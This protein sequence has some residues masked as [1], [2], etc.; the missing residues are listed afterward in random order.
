[1]HQIL[2]VLALMTI[3][4]RAYAGNDPQYPVIFIPG[5]AASS[6]PSGQILNF[7]FNRGYPPE[8]LNLSPSY[9]TLVRKLEKAGYE[10]GITFFAAVYDWR[11]AAAPTDGNY[12]GQLENVTAESVTSGDYSYAVNYLGYWLDQAV[13]ANPG[14]E[15]VD[16][17]THSTGGV[18][19]RAYIQS[20]AYGA[21]YIDKNHVVR[22]LPKIRYLI[23]GAAPTFGAPHSWRPWHGDFQDVLTGFIPTTEIE[24]RVAAMAFAAVIE[25]K[26]ISGPDYDITEDS[27]LAIDKKGNL[28]PDATKF[29]RLYTPMRR[30]LM[31]TYN[32]LQSPGSDEYTNV[33]D[34][35]EVRSDVLLDL[36]ALSTP[37]NNPWLALIG[38]AEGEGGAIATYATGARVKTSY[39]D[40]IIPG[41]IDK[42]PFI[43]T[44]NYVVQLSDNEGSYLPLLA[45]LEPNPTVIPVADSLF[46]RIGNTEEDDQLD[47]DGNGPFVSL[48]GD[49]AE[50]P[51][52]TLVQWA[53]GL[54]LQALRLILYGTKRPDIR[55]IMTSFF[56]TKMSLSLSWTP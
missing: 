7:V 12:D 4:L 55:F 18:L 20:P 41:L 43:S 25:G 53:M 31:A 33:N 36:N 34:L 17:V 35:P 23:M 51:K 47:G 13:Q 37:G 3:A 26:T 14:L 27:I 30:S 54:L 56:S 21:Q 38:I 22:H 1:M 5:F 32:F 10:E 45:L 9:H 15:Y 16:V 28:I 11:M 24:G 44:L 50:D 46:F 8:Y 52:I 42:N 48:I 29:F 49:F 40:F 2:W 39:K 19:A 6:P